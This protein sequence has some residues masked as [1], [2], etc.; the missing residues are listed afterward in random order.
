MGIEVMLKDDKSGAYN[1]E[2]AEPNGSRLNDL[3]LLI[4]ISY[5][6]KQQ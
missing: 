3:T 6:I 1:L 5:T 4:A 2:S